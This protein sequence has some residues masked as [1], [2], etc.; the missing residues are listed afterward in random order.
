[1]ECCHGFFGKYASEFYL[2]FAYKASFLFY[3]KK[4]FAL[5]T[6]LKMADNLT[7]KNLAFDQLDF[8]QFVTREAFV[9]CLFRETYINLGFPMPL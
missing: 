7:I 3:F 8:T 5:V 2:L 6:L 4:L 9:D 1:M